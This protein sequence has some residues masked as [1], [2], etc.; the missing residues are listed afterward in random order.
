MKK[1][2]EFK[3][4]FA[5]ESL[6]AVAAALVAVSASPVLA[7]TLSVGI[8]PSGGGAVSPNYSTTALQDGKTYTM[9]AK[10]AKGFQFTDWT[11][12]T[13]STNAKL[14][15]V[16][17]AGL[18][19]TANFKDT[20]RPTCVVLFPKVKQAVGA[21]VITATGRAS[22]NAGVTAVY[23][24]LNTGDWSPATGTTNWSAP[25]LVLAPGTNVI[26]ACAVD[27]AG[28]YSLTNSIAFSYAVQ[29]MGVYLGENDDDPSG[30]GGFALFV[31]AKEKALVIGGDPYND[32]S[33]NPVYGACTVNAGGQ[34]NSSDSKA[35]A[36]SFT[37][38]SDG[39]VDLAVDASGWQWKVKGNLVTG[40]DFEN[41]AG[42][43]SASASGQTVQ[44]ILSPNGWFYSSSPTHGGGARCQ[45]SAYA[46]PATQAALGHSISTLT[47]HS[48][49]TISATGDKG[50]FTYKRVDP[51]P[52]PQ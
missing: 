38:H 49:G 48:N 44:G 33:G 19:F 12:D 36:T 13:N 10:A 43:Y 41:V 51:L 6:L 27:A 14:T 28:N 46:Q 35:G 2:L 22:D 1:Y 34:G 24:Q 7:D 9:T 40:G 3:S 21:P 31:D 20:Q 17:R 11:G 50:A 16:M 5:R 4:R 30:P 45:F 37:I 52:L 42:A 47:L 8:F 23:F 26:R 25:D 32:D 15:F 29:Y 18:S 39:S